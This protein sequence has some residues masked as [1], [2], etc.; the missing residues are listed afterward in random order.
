MQV[1]ACLFLPFV[2]IWIAR[3]SCFVGIKR[4]QKTFNIINTPYM[5]CAAYIM[6]IYTRL[7]L[8]HV[9]YTKRQDPFTRFNK[10]PSIRFSCVAQEIQAPS[11]SDARK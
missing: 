2:G 9:P 6:R 8:A 11:F 4:N 1:L 3:P 7:P 5:S 10:N